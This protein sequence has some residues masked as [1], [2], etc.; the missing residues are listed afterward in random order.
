MFRRTPGNE[1]RRPFCLLTVGATWCT[2]YARLGA[3]LFVGWRMSTLGSYNYAKAIF[4]A[5]RMIEG[6]SIENGGLP[7]LAHAV[8][9]LAIDGKRVIELDEAMLEKAARLIQHDRQCSLQ[10]NLLHGLASRC[11]CGANDARAA[12][13]KLAREVSNDRR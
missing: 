9:Q 11:D 2:M 1:A 7:Q 3:N 12:L 10:A 13:R 5:T 6:W 4:D 8:S